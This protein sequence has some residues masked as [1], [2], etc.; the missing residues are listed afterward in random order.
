MF[1]VGAG[2]WIG[3]ALLRGLHDALPPQAWRDRVFAF[4]SSARGI[5]LGDGLMARQRP[6]ADLDS[7]DPTPSI[8]FHL[9]FLTKDKLAGMARADYVAANLALSRRV[10]GALEAIGAD[11]LFV[12]SSG[13]AALAGDPAA[14]EDMRVYGALKRDD[15]D[16]FAGWAEDRVER[17]AV[18]TRIYSLSGPF[19]NKHNTYALA[20]FV[21]DALAARPIGVRAPLPV[22]RSYVAIRE[23]VSLV[24]VQLLGQEGP[25]VRR[26]DSGGEAFELGE[27]AGV[28][29]SLFGT[30]VERVAITRADEDRYVGANRDYAALLV[31]A[32]IDSVTLPQQVLETAA[33]LAH[34]DSTK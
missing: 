1:V 14:N 15:E 6:L 18:L 31:E 22:L 28:V 19:I 10:F 26:Y 2:G 3:R 5:D 24:L 30:L 13:A 7:L 27:V 32:G 9:A 17:R 34:Y 16:L 20:S 8:V 4:G 29:A 33:F 21:I 25:T 12:A 23:L 11:R